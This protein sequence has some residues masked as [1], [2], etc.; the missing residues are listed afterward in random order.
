MVFT[1]ATALSTAL[2]SASLVARRKEGND[3]EWDGGG[4]G[5]EEWDGKGYG[6]GS[7]K[8]RRSP[9]VCYSVTV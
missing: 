6:Q 8:N 1:R 9:S 5:I 2:P 7:D 4:E 3:E